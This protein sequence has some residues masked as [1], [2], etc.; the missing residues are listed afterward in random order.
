MF[1]WKLYRAGLGKCIMSKGVGSWD[2]AM[3]TVLNVCEGMVQL[4]WVWMGMGDTLMQNV[5]TV[6]TV[7]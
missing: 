4:C 3:R 7:L 1:G 2:E 6:G 5:C